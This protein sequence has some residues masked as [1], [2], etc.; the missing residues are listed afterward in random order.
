MKINVEVDC[1]PLEA[2]QF[3]GLPNVEPL[4]NAVMAQVESRML[5]EMER[6]SPET[7]MRSWFSLFPQNS[8]QMNQVFSSL[9]KRAAGQD[10]E[11][12]RR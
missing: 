10:Q 4:Q 11:P 1:T 12:P 7:L 9:F 6:F 8:D 2:R 5:A 3:F